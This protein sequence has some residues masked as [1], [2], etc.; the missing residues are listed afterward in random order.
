MDPHP[1]IIS[2]AKKNLQREL[3]NMFAFCFL[4]NSSLSKNNSSMFRI[5][6]RV[7]CVTTTGGFTCNVGGCW[8]LKGF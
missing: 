4:I 5:A 1:F 7:T 8:S 6:S 3:L 2:S